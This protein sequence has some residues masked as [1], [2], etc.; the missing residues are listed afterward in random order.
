MRLP[1]PLEGE[2]RLI[3]DT[4]SVF[5]FD[6]ESWIKISGP[7]I[8]EEPDIVSALAALDSDDG[9]KIRKARQNLTK[10]YEE[11]G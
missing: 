5:I 2:A 1:A 3:H 8:E 4:C 6:G 10:H 11:T 7:R 9:E